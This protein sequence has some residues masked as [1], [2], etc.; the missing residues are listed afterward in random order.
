MTVPDISDDTLVLS[1]FALE[2][3]TFALTRITATMRDIRKSPHWRS[4]DLD[5]YKNYRRTL[6]SYLPK[7]R[8][9]SLSAQDHQDIQQILLSVAKDL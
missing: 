8:S 2:D 4:Q 7:A 1:T 3:I 9:D 5:K 6:Q